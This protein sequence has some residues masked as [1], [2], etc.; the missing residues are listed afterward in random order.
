MAGGMATLTHAPRRA[1]LWL[2]RP[3]SGCADPVSHEHQSS[4]AIQEALPRV[5][6]QVDAQR[7][8]LSD[9]RQGK[10]CS[11]AAG[12]LRS[13]AVGTSPSAISLAE[14]RVEFGVGPD[15][16]DLLRAAA[17]DSDLGSPLQ[18]HLV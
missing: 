9:R 14:H 17:G 3:I 13:D 10:S 5:P 2:H 11:S 6:A 1:W 15:L 18:R 16:A 12:R 4:R 8:A 7:P